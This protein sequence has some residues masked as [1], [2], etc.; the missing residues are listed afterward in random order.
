MD[1]KD[2]LTGAEI[3]SLVFGHETRGRMVFPE[4]LPMKRTISADGAVSETIGQTT[5]TGTSWVQ[6]DFLCRAFPGG[7][8]SCGAIFRN[9]FRTPR[10]E[11]E[12]KAVYRFRTVRVFG[13]QVKRRS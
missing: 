7:R 1:P 9:A 10:R 2:R 11:D 3:R 4:F 12:Y 5:R 6:G 8:T 13:R